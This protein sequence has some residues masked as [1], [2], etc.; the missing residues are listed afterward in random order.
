M[1]KKKLNCYY[2]YSTISL[3]ISVFREAEWEAA[4][5]HKKSDLL[6]KYELK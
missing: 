1:A 5:L 4:H 3:D 2:E 6:T